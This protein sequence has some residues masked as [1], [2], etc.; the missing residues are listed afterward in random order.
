MFRRKE[1]DLEQQ[2]YSRS[3]K[4]EC[5]GQNQGLRKVGK[6]AVP[7]ADRCQ[8]LAVDLDTPSGHV[9]G[10]ASTSARAIVWC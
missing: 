7:T 10:S 9:Q 8:N 3:C 2:K 1:A 6:V 4:S 5:Y